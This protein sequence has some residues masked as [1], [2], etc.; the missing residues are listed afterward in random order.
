MVAQDRSTSE[1]A[2]VDEIERLEIKCGLYPETAAANTYRGKKQAE[3]NR[4]TVGVG[5]KEC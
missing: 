3:E 2:A 4:E 5:F 1:D